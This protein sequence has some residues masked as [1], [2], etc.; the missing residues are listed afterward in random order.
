MTSSCNW[1]N[2]K[3]KGVSDIPIENVIYGAWTAIE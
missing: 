2:R 3:G 1:K